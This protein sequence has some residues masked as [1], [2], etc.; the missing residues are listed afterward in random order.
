MMSLQARESLSP[1]N[2]P[3][4][5]LRMYPVDSPRA[6]ARLI[7]LALNLPPSSDENGP[8]VMAKGLWDQD[9][10]DLWQKD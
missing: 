3:G 8:L 9:E 4:R 5:P 1:I 7:A 10:P 6:K 2:Y